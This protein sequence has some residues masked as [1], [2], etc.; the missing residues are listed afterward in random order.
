MKK[1]F[2]ALLCAA[3]LLSLAVA[4]VSCGT[5]PCEEH[6]DE[7]KN[8][9]CDVCSA[10]VEIV[11]EEH[12][13]TDKNKICDVC[14]ERIEDPKPIEVNVSFTIKDQ[15][16]LA[17]PGVAVSLR[18]TASNGLYTA[19]A[20]ANGA[21]SLKLPVGTY[22]AEYDNYTTDEVYYYPESAAHTIVITAETSAY[23]IKFVNNTPNGTLERP[24]PLT[25]GESNSLVIPTGSGYHYIIYRSNNYIVNLEG[26]GIKVVYAGSE[27]TPDADGKIV[28][29]LLGDSTNSQESLYVENVTD[30]EISV[31]IDISS[32][33]GTTMDNPFIIETLGEEIVNEDMKPK[34]DR[35][36]YSYIA[37][38]AGTLQLTVTS[39]K[40]YAGLSN[41]TTGI[42]VS[43]DEA[44]STTLTVEVSAGDRIIIDCAT[45]SF[46]AADVSFILEY[47]EADA[48]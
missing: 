20:D 26:T 10:E 25:V 39:T 14:K 8:G 42:S 35:L 48:E 33:Q 1:I 32:K 5:P 2:S 11:C 28:F 23:E 7:D 15:D 44:D 43:T 46:S 29:E 31:S 21:F 34:T 6:K 13:D 4:V 17:V 12:K 24:Y 27:Y 45:Q 22:A 16:G 41:M 9:V 19:T 37:A 40:S 36:Y 30:S 18:G 3:L 47:K 38:E